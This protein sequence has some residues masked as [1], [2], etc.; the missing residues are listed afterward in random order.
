MQ[1]NNRKAADSSLPRV[2]EGLPTL[3]VSEFVAEKNNALAET[4][5]VV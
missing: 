4:G 1:N 3:Y 2:T 5:V